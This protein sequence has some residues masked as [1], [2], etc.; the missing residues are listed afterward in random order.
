MAVLRLEGWR[1]NHKR[2]EKIL[3]QEGLKVQSK[4]PKKGLEKNWLITF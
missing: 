4:Q 1:V 3:R 2:G